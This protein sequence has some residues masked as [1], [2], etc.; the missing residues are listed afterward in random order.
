[1]SKKSAWKPALKLNRLAHCDWKFGYMWSS[2]EA[3]HLE[4]HRMIGRGIDVLGAAR[5]DGVEIAVGRD[6]VLDVHD[7]VGSRVDM[8]PDQDAVG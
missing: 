6:F 1:M 8:R 5:D 4:A 3:D 7:L 2:S